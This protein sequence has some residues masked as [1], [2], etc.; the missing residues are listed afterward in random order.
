MFAVFRETTYDPDK[1]KYDSEQFRKFQQ[2]H[3]ARSGYR[4]TVV[5]DAGDGRFLTLTLWE[6]AEDMDAA[7][8]TLGPIVQGLL[9]PL[10]TTPAK[11][12]GTGRVVVDDLRR[13][14][15]GDLR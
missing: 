2:A 12:L 14:R 8:V 4:G 7:R 11:L 15:G 13:F 1:P 5:A 3:S 6:T 9:D 10:M